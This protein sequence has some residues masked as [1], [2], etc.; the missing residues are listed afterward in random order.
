MELEDENL[1]LCDDMLRAEIEI[2][3]ILRSVDEEREAEW[4][5][6]FET[7]LRLAHEGRREF[8]RAR[9]LFDSLGG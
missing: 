2:Y 7:R 6:R 8:E 9:A 5:A 4:R 3:H 1:I